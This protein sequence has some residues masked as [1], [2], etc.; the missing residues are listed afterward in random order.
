MAPL[1]RVVSQ[2]P[3]PYLSIPAISDYKGV[4][5]ATVE[6]WEYMEIIRKAADPKCSSHLQNSI[7]TIDTILAIPRMNKMLKG[8]FGLAD[9]QHDEDFVSVL[10]V[11][12]LTPPVEIC[13]PMLRIQIAFLCDKRVR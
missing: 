12:S 6:N 5:H 8:L 10:G 1:P 4:T 13:M 11:R 7:F 3:I 2:P 9:L